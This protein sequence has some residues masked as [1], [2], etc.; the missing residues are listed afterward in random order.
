MVDIPTSAGDV[1]PPAEVADVELYHPKS[2]WTKYVFSQ[3]AKV[4][5][6]QYSLTAFAIGF[7][8]LVLSWLI[9]LQ[10]GFPGYFSFIDADHYYQFIT[11]HGM[12]MVIYLLTALF[13]GGFGN[14]LIPLMV[15]ARD[16]VFPYANM[17]SYWLYLLAVIVLVTG[18]FAPGGPTGAG[19]TLYPPQALTS[20]TPGGRDWGIILMLSSLIIFIIGF[21][22]GGLNYVVTVL[23]GRARGM[24]LMRMPLTVWGIFTATVMALLAFPALFVAA[25]MMLFDRLLGTSFFMPAIVEMGEQLPS[26]GG[27]PILFQHLFW[28]FG[29][30][31]VYIVA[32]PAFGI[33]SDLISTHARKNIFGYR[34]M[35]WAIVI[36]GALSFVVWA[37]HMYVSG[38][39]PNFGFF[40][41]TTTLIIAVPTA[42]K[43]Y[44]WVLTLWRGDIHLTLPMLFAIAFIVTFVNGG[45]TGLFLGNVVVDVPLSDTMFVVAHFHMV[46]GVAPIMVV[47]GAIYHWYPKITGRMLDEVL[48][49]IHFWVT[50]VGAYAI[51]FPMHYVGL[52]GV[53][54]RYFE[55]GDTVFIPPSVHTLSMFI[56]VAA[57]VVGAAQIVFLFNLVWSLFH[58]REAGGN[59]WRATTLEWQTPETP[60]AHGNWG[61]DLPI[62]YRWAYDYSVPGAPED[63]IPQNQPPMVGLSRAPA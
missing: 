22:M 52:V 6:I 23:Q 16:M 4:I 26:D 20:G 38:M 36:I 34:M 30:P 2:W 35:V 18:F 51:F 57:L 40:F 7:V 11:M 15:G 48:G 19:W 42:I 39:N 28:F 13:L 63:F 17:L 47:F 33:V 1:I 61:K 24:T 54:R 9:R 31:E 25:V 50:F 5:A 29:H 27:S 8:A 37:H 32:L 45:L 55:L 53:P 46:M 44:N 14:Y 3:D 60:P 49:R 10:L 43:V 56:S 12:I 59:P 62:V 41:A 21:T 58:G